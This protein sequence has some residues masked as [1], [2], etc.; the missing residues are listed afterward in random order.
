MYFA[1]IT[2]LKPSLLRLRKMYLQTWNLT[3]TLS[4]ADVDN[5]Q[6][7]QKRAGWLNLVHQEIVETQEED[8][9]SNRTASTKGFI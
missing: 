3:W 6:E 9:A 2:I 7:K 4:M 8:M 5:Q 1:I